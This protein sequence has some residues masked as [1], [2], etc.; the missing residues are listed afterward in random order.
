[1]EP[2]QFYLLIKA[3]H[4][5]FMVAWFAGLFYLP[6]LLVYHCETFG[7]DGKNID[8]L[9]HKR[10]KIMEQRLLKQIT[11]PAAILTLTSGIVLIL[12]QGLNWFLTSNWMHLKIIV[13][14]SLL[15][16][17]IYIGYQVRLFRLEKN[18]KTKKFFKIINELPVLALAAIVLLAIFKPELAI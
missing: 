10:F 4:L 9:G 1:M 14:L 7:P 5:I 13:V 11:T 3:L 18:K 17:H 16:Y 12:I 8:Q 15:T 2:Y 6:R